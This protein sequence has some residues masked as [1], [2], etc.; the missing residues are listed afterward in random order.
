MSDEDE[1]NILL[2]R[3]NQR[4]RK[5][6]QRAIL[7]TLIPIVMAGVLIFFSWQQVASATQRLN[8]TNQQF[9]V[10]ST[11]LPQSQHQMTGLQAELDQATTKAATLQAQSDQYQKDAE[12]LRS[13]VDQYKAE[14]TD[15]QTKRNSLQNELNE[16]KKQIDNSTTQVNEMY[17]LRSYLYEGNLFTIY[18]ELPL[19][20]SQAELFYE[21]FSSQ[22]QAS[23]LPGGI[24]P[25]KFDSPGFAVYMLTKYKLINGSLDDNHYA[26][27]N[28][29]KPVTQPAIGDIVFYETGYTM[30][31]LMDTNGQPF[32]IGMTPLGV[33]ALKYD[34]AKIRMIGHIAYP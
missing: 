4:E 21:I 11:Q 33:Q 26:L 15:L 1:L 22:G 25:E 34:F 32:V 3:V 20:P 6:Q 8:E 31:Y 2:E 16:L 12:S 23:F 9:A 24:G 5:A 30:F 29:L 27:I 7:Y 18:K 13:Q 14:I 10:V 19:A 17:G 28:M